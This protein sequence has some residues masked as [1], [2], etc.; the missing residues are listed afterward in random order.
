MKARI[1]WL[2]LN[3]FALWAFPF[4]GA[5]LA[6][7]EQPAADKGH[8][9]P[10]ARFVGGQWVIHGH[11]SNGEALTARSVYEWGIANKIIQFFA[12]RIPHVDPVPAAEPPIETETRPV[13]LSGKVG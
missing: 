10:L 3:A 11:W 1:L 12:K 9:A 5:P 6:A 7:D 4:P 13:E 2:F 8:L